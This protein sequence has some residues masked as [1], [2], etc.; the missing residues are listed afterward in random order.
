M[1]A[2]GNRRS[3]LARGILL[4]PVGLVLAGVGV[5]VGYLLLRA[6]EAEPAELADLVLRGRTLVLLLNTLG[7]AA[8]VLALGSTLA[9]PLAWLV[10][11]TDLPA[12]GAVTLL[13]VLPLAVPG[14]VMAYALLGLGG[15]VG[16]AAR[17]FGLAVPRPS[18][19]VGALL[20]L[21]LYTFPYLFLNLRAAL[22]GLDPAQ[23]EAARS[24]GL[25]PTAVARQVVLPHLRPAFS[26]GALLVGLHVLGDF[27]AVSLM[28]FETI[29]Y[30]LY[31]QYAA[32]YDRTYAA[33]LALLGLALAALALLAEARALRGLRLARTGSGAAR[34]PRALPLGP[35]RWPA[36]GFVGL[37]GL[38]GVGVPVGTLTYWLLRG[39]EVAVGGRLGE[40]LGNAVLASAPAAVLAAALAL[41]LAVLG[42]RRAGPMS[43]AVERVAYLGYATPPLAFA[44]AL[45]FFSLRA[46]PALYQTLGLLVVA[47][48][49]HFL[50]E[51]LGPVRSALYQAPPRLEEAARILGRSRLGAF[52]SATFPLLRRG[53]ATSAAF[54]FLACLKELPIT[55]LLSPVGFDTLALRV[56]GYAS[57]ALFGA[58]APYALAI[59]ACSAAFVGLLLN[60]E[61]AP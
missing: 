9:F 29:S 1:S 50:A 19:Y 13:G 3:A 32:A 44:L 53:L 54:V 46:A 48:A 24:L 51:A 10:T 18:G 37:V 56:W 31:L 11:R 60:Q 6:F 40:A 23:E 27:G 5:P 55:F 45:V 12:K 25:S 34:R 47:Y 36:F 15:D 2:L 38:A 16:V 39:T 4:L 7:L 58:A 42:V 26:A 43:R 17:L 59:V 52:F 14:Y 41:P 8:G 49:L 20:A 21:S 33:W 35:W 61:A 22:L 30:A 57:E 28:R